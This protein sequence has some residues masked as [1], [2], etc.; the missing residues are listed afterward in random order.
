MNTM[1]VFF[2]SYPIDS[3]TAPTLRSGRN[4]RNRLLRARHADRFSTRP[5]ILNHG[6]IPIV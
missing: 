3:A 1:Y 4:T 6:I 2:N 5:K